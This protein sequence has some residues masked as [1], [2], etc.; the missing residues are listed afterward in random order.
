[1]TRPLKEPRKER[2]EN[3]DKLRKTHI[4][5][6]Q[7]PLMRTPTIRKSRNKASKVLKKTKKTLV[8][9]SAITVIRRGIIYSIAPNPQSQKTSSSLNSLHIDNC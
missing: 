1:M 8:I 2:K 6:F 3:E 9:S 7:K 5:Q 4:P